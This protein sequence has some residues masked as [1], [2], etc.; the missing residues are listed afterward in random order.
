MISSALSISLAL[1]DKWTMIGGAPTDTKKDDD[2][3]ASLR[4]MAEGLES[5]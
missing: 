2:L 1:I 5:D 4:E 3:S